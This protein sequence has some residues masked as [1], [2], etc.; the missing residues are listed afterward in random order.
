MQIELSSDSIDFKSTVIKSFLTEDDH[1]QIELENN[2]ESIIS[3]ILEFEDD[4]AF[5]TRSI[6]EKR[7]S[8]RYQNFADIIV[9]LQDDQSSSR[10]ATASIF[11]EFRRKEINDFLEKQ[12][13]EL[14]TIDKV[15]ENIRI[16]NSRFVDEIKHSG[17]SQ[18]YEKSRLVIQ[19][20]NDQE[21]TLVLT[22]IFT[23]QRMS[24][25]IILALA[26][27]ISDCYL[28]LRDIT[29]AYVQSSTSLNRIF[30][31]RSSLELE[32]S[33]ESILRVI[34]SLYEVFE[35]DAH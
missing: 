18:A 23:I 33:D 12:V 10:S 2:L 20:Y 15:L 24:Q 28:Y 25:R 30:F 27:S 3:S 29:Q 32:L 21:K 7:L 22:Q 13:F 5:L 11:V 31:I 35:I 14:I 19:A 17:T 16:F 34:K 8:R 9:F 26:S 1:V 6:R 4:F